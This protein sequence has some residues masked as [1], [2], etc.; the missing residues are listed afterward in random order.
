MNR[1][2]IR[3]FFNI[4]PIPGHQPFHDWMA[5]AEA[6]LWFWISLWHLVFV[7]IGFAIGKLTS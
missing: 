7:G 1:E 6:R 3:G 5:G 2:Y 4:Q